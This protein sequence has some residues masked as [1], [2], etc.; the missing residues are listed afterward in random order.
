MSRTDSSD[1]YHLTCDSAAIEL[2]LKSRPRV[3]DRFTVARVLPSSKR[4]LV[5]PFCFL[6]HLGPAE[7]A[8]G[9]GMDVRPHP[10]VCL[11]TVSYL[12]EGE[13]LHRDSLGSSQPIRPG[14]INWM[15][16]GRGITH[17]ERTPPELRATGSRIHLLQLW[18]ALPLAQEES[19]PSFQHHPAA[20][21]PELTLGEA[22]IRVLAGSGFGLTAPVK[23][24]SPLFFAEVSMP[25]RGSLELPAEHRERAAYV[26]EGAFSCGDQRIEARDMAVFTADTRPVLI[27]EQSTRLMLLGGAALEGPRYIDWNFVASSK[28]RLERAKEDWRAQRFPS[29]PGDDQE[30]IPLP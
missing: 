7:L 23:T 24:L 6:D 2:I 15:S 22:R 27:A 10:H 17:S 5:G 25:S 14:A 26:V 11:A 19:E 13:V 12:F 4:R 20:S 9:E 3:I 29:I 21:L 8:P 28:S 30:F 16:A 1:P 18:V